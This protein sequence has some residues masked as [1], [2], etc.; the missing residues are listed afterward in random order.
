M[1]SE[2]LTLP[3]LRSVKFTNKELTALTGFSNPS[4][5]A[6]QPI[7]EH[8]QV[9]L[10]PVYADR[11][12]VQSIGDAAEIPA[13][14][15]LPVED[16]ADQRKV[17]VVESQENQ[18]NEE[19][20]A[21][22]LTS[23]VGVITGLCN[24][25]LHL[26]SIPPKGGQPTKAPL[27]KG[28]NLPISEIN[29]WGYSNNFDDFKNLTD[30]NIGLYHAASN[31]LALDLD[32]MEL[33][34]QVFEDTTDFNLI[35][36]LED[37]L[38]VEIKSP[39]A[40]RGKLLFKVPPGFSGSLKQ[41]KKPKKDKP[42]EYEVIFELRCGNCQDVIY[43]QHP[44]GGNYQLIGNPAAIP[45]A[46]PVLLDMLLHWDAWKPCLDSALG[47]EQEPP[48]VSAHKPQQGSNLKG[49][50]DPIQEFNQAYSVEDILIRNGYRQVSPDRFIRPNSSSRAPGI[51]IL[52]NCK[53]GIDRAFSFAGDDL[54]DGYG[55]S[56][57]DTMRL[58]EC[59]G[60]Y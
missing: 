11:L 3:M 21:V 20:P 18:V 13:V 42:K 44:E 22:D 48:K 35:A 57:W 4:V 14:P 52:R 6:K 23:Q 41:L 26:V 58:L 43:G 12:A 39:K 31:T 16:E 59:G 60:Q 40:N 49:Y 33:A 45:E 46:P 8:H 55:H 32:D 30:C 1:L 17:A 37:D 27:A 36:W 7:T 51:K 25:G 56:A 24:A 2:N 15:A 50:R 53:D 9:I 5:W 28:W 34:R 38:R 29:P 19:A 10:W 54:N 47:I